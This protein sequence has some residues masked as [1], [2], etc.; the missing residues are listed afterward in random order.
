MIIF[1]IN[2]SWHLYKIYIFLILLIKIL[3]FDNLIY[4][5]DHNII[6]LFIMITIIFHTHSWAL[7]DIFAR[8]YFFFQEISNILTLDPQ[9]IEKLCF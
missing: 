5:I 8:K 6:D 1:L 9:Y 4:D 2:Q 7:I 3:N